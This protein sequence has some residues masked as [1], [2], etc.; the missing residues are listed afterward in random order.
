MPI[1]L[2]CG[3]HVTGPGKKEWK[4]VEV[5]AA[6]SRWLRSRSLE[7]KIGVAVANTLQ[8]YFPTMNITRG[9]EIIRRGDDFENRE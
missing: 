4:M 9:G 3:E 7:D 8:D 2:A 6:G 5:L 1:S